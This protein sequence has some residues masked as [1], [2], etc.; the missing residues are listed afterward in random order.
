MDLDDSFTNKLLKRRKARKDYLKVKM[1]DSPAR[2]KR[3]VLVEEQQ[4][5]SKDNKELNESLKCLCIEQVFSEHE[6]KE[7]DL[8][9]EVKENVS[10]KQGMRENIFM[11]ENE[12]MEEEAPLRVKSLAMLRKKYSAQDDLNDKKAA[13]DT[14]QADEPPTS[15]FS[16]NHKE[17]CSTRNRLRRLAA[18]INR[19]EDNLMRPTVYA[20][21]STKKAPDSAAEEVEDTLNCSF[22]PS[23]L[24]L[25]A[26]RALF[27]QAAI[28]NQVQSKKQTIK[29][30]V[31]VA[32]RAAMFENAPKNENR[33]RTTHPNP[34][35]KSPIK[36]TMKVRSPVKP[37]VALGCVQSSAVLK[38]SPVRQSATL[39]RTIA[40]PSAGSPAKSFLIFDHGSPTRPSAALTKNPT[41][42]STGSPAKSSSTFSWD[43]PTRPSAALTKN[44][45]KPSTGSP[46]KSSP[47]SSCESPAKS[48][49]TFSWDSPT[50][51]SAALIMN[52]TK[53]PTG[54]L[55]QSAAFNRGS[56]AKLGVN[57][58]STTTPTKSFIPKPIISFNQWQC[59]KT[60]NMESE[61]K[62]PLSSLVDH[63]EKLSS[64]SSVTNKQSKEEVPFHN[65]ITR[66]EVFSPLEEEQVESECDEEQIESE[67]EEQP[68]QSECEG[69]TASECEES[70]YDSTDIEEESGDDNDDSFTDTSSF[71][72]NKFAAAA[73]IE[74]ETE[75][76]DKSSLPDYDSVLG[77]S[78]YSH[79]QSPPSSSNYSCD[80]ANREDQS[81]HQPLLHTVSVYRKLVKESCTPPSRLEPVPPLNEKEQERITDIRETIKRLQEEVVRQQNRIG[82][83]TK[84]INWLVSTKPEYHGSSE[85][86]EAE[87]VLLIATQKHQACLN[88][89]QRLKFHRSL[90]S[91]TEDGYGTLTITNMELPL[92]RDFIAAQ[93]DGKINDVHSFLCLVRRGA[94]V[95]ETQVVSTN[96][97]ITD[98]SLHF[99][100]LIRFKN[101]P[102][103]FSIVFEVFTLLRQDNNQ[104]NQQTKKEGLSGIRRDHSK[105]KLTPKKKKG[106]GDLP[107]VSS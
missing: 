1:M 65:L 102:P 38:A 81:S 18:D 62:R 104:L 51:P 92:K 90:G 34:I 94:Q 86:V 3:T 54:S 87:K 39:T 105:T 72:S 63:W 9:E 76:E 37:G 45:T 89:I 44:P 82:Q 17:L 64:S 31:S 77:D 100:S 98:G 5:P 40:K 101:L 83:S 16:T 84:L 47:I 71:N 97:E 56:P 68:V 79:F 26:R 55:A 28:E 50:R 8:T 52:P 7:D 29:P 42:P 23:N 99:T 2:R 60:T 10:V 19:W 41:K 46:A 6:V 12:S 85:E 74:T 75:N 21:S 96:D 103:D 106:N 78:C 58:G 35:N 48:S 70:K 80:E 69:Q 20:T 32:Q 73:G 88:E 30:K 24:P 53:T 49:S 36:P 66:E 93:L 91:D 95:I 61:K 14:Q 43:S 25:S 33:V 57:G 67:P 15:V 13:M 59:A 4:I 107:A 22:E 11:K 27:E